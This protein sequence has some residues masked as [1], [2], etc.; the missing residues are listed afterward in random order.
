MIPVQRQAKLLQV[1]DRIRMEI[2]EREFREV[3]WWT[4]HTLETVR[5]EYDFRIVVDGNMEFYYE[6][7]VTVLVRPGATVAYTDRPIDVPTDDSVPND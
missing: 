2:G 6:D 5:E 4:I 7:L 1:G 3:G